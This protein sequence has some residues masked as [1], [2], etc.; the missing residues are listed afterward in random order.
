MLQ[1]EGG[2]KMNRLLLY[3]MIVGFIGLVTMQVFGQPPEEELARVE[4]DGTLYI[5]GKEYEK[6]SDAESKAVLKELRD[7]IQLQMQKLEED[8]HLF[9]QTDYLLKELYECKGGI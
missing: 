3:L 4:S 5:L 9:E 1:A 2:D 8:K 7:L 6:L